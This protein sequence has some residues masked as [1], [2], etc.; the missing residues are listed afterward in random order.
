MAFNQTTWPVNSGTNNTILVC[1]RWLGTG[2]A[3][4]TLIS[5]RGV[6]TVDQTATGLYT[7]TFNNVGGTLLG[8]FLQVMNTAGTAAAQKVANP[9]LYSAS[10]KTYT[11]SVV[12]MDATPVLA[13]L[14]ASDELQIMAV[15]SDASVP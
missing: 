9:I 15:W 4:A 8:L 10:A 3:D 7:I 1:S 13:D 14:A 12:N 6:A 2:A 5:G 11:I